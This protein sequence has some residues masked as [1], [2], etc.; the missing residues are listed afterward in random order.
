MEKHS[1]LNPEEELM[2]RERSNLFVQAIQHLSENQRIAYSLHHFEDLSYKEISES[3][4][5]SLSAVESLIFRAKQQLLK[6]L[7][8][9]ILQ[10]WI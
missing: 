8:D 6:Q 10:N 5:L 3:M 4:S 9:P 2:E 7:K 1:P